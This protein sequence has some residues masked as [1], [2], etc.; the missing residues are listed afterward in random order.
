MDLK[1]QA[2]LTQFYYSRSRVRLEVKWGKSILEGNHV[3]KFAQLLGHQL[4]LQ[5]RGDKTE[6]KQKIVLL[7]LLA[8]KR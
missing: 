6:R 5:E 4:L 3:K 7:K 8:I 1:N 2:G